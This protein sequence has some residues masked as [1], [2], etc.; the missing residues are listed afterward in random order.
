MPPNGVSTRD[1]PALLDSAVLVYGELAGEALSLGI[2]PAA[3][4]PLPVPLTTAGVNA[5]A[6]H[7]QLIMCASSLL[8]GARE[9][10]IW[11]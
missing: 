5:V 9:Q 11:C 4:P 8:Y 7:L 10:L 3:I 6:H 2:P 1:A